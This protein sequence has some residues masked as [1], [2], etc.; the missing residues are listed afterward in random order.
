MARAPSVRGPVLALLLLQLVLICSAQVRLTMFP[1]ASALSICLH[2]LTWQGCCRWVFSPS[3]CGIT[4]SI[5][6]TNWVE[7]VAEIVSSGKFIGHLFQEW[8]E[9]KKKKTASEE[10]SVLSLLSKLLHTFVYSWC[11]NQLYR[12]FAVS[13]NVFYKQAISGCTCS[14]VFFFPYRLCSGM[15]VWGIATVGVVCFQQ[16]KLTFSHH[17]IV[18]LLRGLKDPPALLDLQVFQELMA[19]M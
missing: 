11:R 9:K 6:P 16:F 19:L 4:R 10:T 5:L 8:R 13:I 2:S 15:S 7:I 14:L 17:I 1:S 18:I 12:L 3:S